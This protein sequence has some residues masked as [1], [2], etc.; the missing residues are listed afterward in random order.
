MDDDEAVRDS[1]AALLESVGL[2]VVVFA[3]GK[4]FLAA[5]DPRQRGCLLLD[6]DLPDMHGTEVLQALFA[7]GAAL[8]VIVITGR[9]GGAQRRSW[10]EAAYVVTLLDKPFQE[11]ALLTAIHDALG[12][13][14]PT[15]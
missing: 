14:A 8:P 7:A 2:P 15:P 4:D 1:L 6:L 11:Q 13:R 12:R 5:Y 10:P 9:R 3:S